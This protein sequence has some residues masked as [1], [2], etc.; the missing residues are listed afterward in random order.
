MASSN[1]DKLLRSRIK[2][3]LYNIN[4]FCDQ[5]AEDVDIIVELTHP[6]KRPTKIANVCVSI[7]KN[8][9]N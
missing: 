9:I 8:I 6:T 5:V 4:K 1:K 7:I 3:N 2:K